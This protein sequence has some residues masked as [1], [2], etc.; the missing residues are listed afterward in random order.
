MG[1][2][3][4][5]HETRSNL[6]VRYE[7]VVH[8]YSLP[9]GK[10]V[11]LENLQQ[12]KHRWVRSRGK[13]AF[14]AGGASGVAD[15]VIV[16]DVCPSSTSHKSYLLPGPDSYNRLAFLNSPHS[17]TNTV[18]AICEGKRVRSVARGLERLNVC[19]G[20]EVVQ[21]NGRSR[22]ASLVCRR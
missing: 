14:R 6:T 21:L 12:P 9:T 20:S 2:P 5:K 3:R 4:G 17:S 10:S 7:R 15:P 11:H 13:T 1:I 16:R 8:C 19:R 22:G 18:M